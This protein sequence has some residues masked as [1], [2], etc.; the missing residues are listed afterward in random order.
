MKKLSQSVS[1]DARDGVAVLIS[2]NPPVNAMS[3][4][5]R[6]GLVDGLEMAQGDE[7]VQAIVIH[8]EG[9]TFFP[10]M[11][12]TEFANPNVPEAPTTTGVIEKLESASKPVVAAIHGTALGGGLE[13][14]LGC[15]YRVAVP[16]AKLGLP[17]VK[18]GIIP[19]AGGTVRLPRVMGVQKALEM[20]TSG[21]PI[22]A[23]Q[24]LDEGLVD[25]I[26]EGDLLTGAIAFAKKVVSE[27]KPLAKIRDLEEK[28]EGARENPAAFDDFRKSIARRT[29]GFKAPEA[30]IRSVE[31]AVRLPFDDAIRNERELFVECQNS[32]E[33]RAQ[34]YF[35]FAERQ[36][37]KV[38]DVPKDTSTRE[39]KSVGVI[40]AGTMGGGISMNFLNR[41]IPV[42]LLEATQEALDRGLGII[43]KNYASTAKKGRIT[44]EDAKQRMSLLTGSLDY[45]ALSAVDLVI[46][47]V[48][49]DMDLKKSVF[50]RI[51]KICKP[52]CVLA[53]NTSYLNI[54][55]IAAVTSRPQDVIGLHFFSPAN[56]MRLMEIV[57]GEQTSKEVLATCM[58]LGT[59]IG[60]VAVV[61][62]VCR[63][64]VGNRIL[65]ARM[66]QSEDL[67][68]KNAMPKEIDQIVFDFGFPMGPFAMRD[69]AGLD[70]GWLREDTPDKDTNIRHLLCTRG[71]RGQK[72][73]GGFYD[74]QEGSRTPIP[75]AEVE[76]LIEEVS[77]NAGI[78]RREIPQE[79]MLKRM[80]YAMVN[81]AA[82]ILDEGIAQRAA[83]IDVIWVY[84][85]GWPTY[86][87][88][89]TYYADQIGLTSI[90]EDL[91]RFSKEYDPELEPAP[92]LR[93]LAQEGKSFRE[94]GG[95]P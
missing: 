2:N 73:G 69:L 91:E 90:V 14:A 15:H 52:G 9:R 44:E 19:G 39:I 53:S 45:Q 61:V 6:Q 60:K 40:G 33:A 43:E 89:L 64:F 67:L 8:C 42:T 72:T 22:S 57:R 46:E 55:E 26:V 51:D 21:N 92:L 63:G 86:R 56:V 76:Q 3:Y 27:N 82:K 66:R 94:Y 85:Y 10:G 50:E 65:S 4:H 41:G 20:M 18:L 74:Y 70:I 47:A 5:V 59:D 71:R 32:P 16:S 87:G 23:K 30:I 29:R 84:G 34:Q 88:G 1:Y 78:T 62:G 80:I 11:D 28:L 17:E 13:T 37:K 77:K 75:N 79:D 83:A 54:N 31:A 25:E 58:K 12:I 93:E 68:L 48:F 35:F 49:E 7:D 38:S 81:E 24:A 36:A 95:N